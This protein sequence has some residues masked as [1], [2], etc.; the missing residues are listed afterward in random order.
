MK[1]AKVSQNKLKYFKN[2]GYKLFIVFQNFT[3]NI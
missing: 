2:V 1:Y 3:K